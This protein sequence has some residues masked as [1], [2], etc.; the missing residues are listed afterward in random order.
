MT[1]NGRQKKIEPCWTQCDR[2]GLPTAGSLRKHAWYILPGRTCSRAKFA[3]VLL[4][5][6]AAILKQ[7]GYGLQFTTISEA[8]ITSLMG[9]SRENKKRPTLHT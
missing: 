9:K 6:N 2:G 4:V 8:E 1:G 3:E 7:A 5:E